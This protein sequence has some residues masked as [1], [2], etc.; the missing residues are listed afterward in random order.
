MITTHGIIKD[1]DKATS[2]LQEIKDCVQ[3]Q[4]QSDCGKTSLVNTAAPVN[5]KTVQAVYIEGQNSIVN[6]LLIPTVSIVTRWFT[7]QQEKSSIIWG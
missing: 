7:S 6:N 1:Q 4:L 3:T 5:Q 2:I